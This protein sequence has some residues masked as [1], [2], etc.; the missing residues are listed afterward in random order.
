MY[1]LVLIICAVI[2][3]TYL[4]L[5]TPAFGRLPGGTRLKKISLLPNYEQ[6]VLKNISPTPM[7]PAGI[8]Y[9]TIVR[10]MLK[11]DPN[12]IPDRTLPH[13]EP[14]FN[15]NGGAYLTWFGHSSYLLQIGPLKVLVDPV[16]S[17]R[18][19]PFSFIGNKNYKGTDFIRAED[20][21]EID[22]LLI[23]HDHYDHMDYRTLLKFKDKT[24]HV[25]T[26]LGA[27]AHLERWG[28]AAD[29]ITE[30][31]W[32]EEAVLSGL[33][34]IATPAR[35]FTGRGFK[36]NRTLWS[37]FVL[38]TPDYRLYLGGD[39]GFDTHFAAIGE[40]YGPFDLAVLE[41]GQ[42][43]EFWP[44]IHMFPEQ[45]VRA[46]IALRA[47]V[48]LPVHWG[49]FSLALHAWNDPINRV[50]KSAEEL[51]MKITTPMLGETVHIGSF[52]PDKK[53]WLI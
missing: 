8:S 28:F 5:H 1:T 19:S 42:Y 49:K 3:L 11:R 37:G 31:A 7:K 2:S 43:N 40:T 48:L 45:T 30:L 46:A 16:F 32:G 44:Y 51:N 34:F 33:S 13:L 21:P 4:V 53:W 52:Y 6:G 20:F 36:R 26:S 50:T 18:T 14:E 22:I 24:K 35:H 38:K 12:R 29:R 47:K 10:G 41:C 9:L 23:T 39:S 25:L 17:G 27:G 15:L